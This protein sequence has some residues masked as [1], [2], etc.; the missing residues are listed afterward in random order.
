MNIFFT[1]SVRGGRTHQPQYADIVEILKEYGMVHSSHVSDDALSEYGET[2]LSSKEIF[3]RELSALAKSDVVVAEVT[4]PSLGVGYLIA[5]ASEQKKKIVALYKGT[6]TLQLSA[7]IK[8][9]ENLEVHTYETLED[10]E[11]ALVVLNGIKKWAVLPS[12]I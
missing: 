1:G 5:A 2:S 4:T 7:I 11:N 3:E 12:R 6:D 9:D 10:I 8:G